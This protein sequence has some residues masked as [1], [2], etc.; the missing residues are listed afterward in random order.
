MANDAGTNSK[1][2]KAAVM[3]SGGC[4]Q[5]KVAKELGVTPRT[6]QRWQKEPGFNDLKND[7]ACEILNTTMKATAEYLSQDVK[8]LFSYQEKKN[9]ILKECAHLDIALAVVLPMVQEGDLRA[10]DSLIRI[11]ERRCKLL[12]LDQPRSNIVDAIAV[13]AQHGIIKEVQAVSAHQIFDEVDFKLSQIG[14]E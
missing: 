12:A 14:L 13:L 9:L 3:L 7:V 11:S 4:P 2:I 1:K 5:I 6:L 8:P 10:I